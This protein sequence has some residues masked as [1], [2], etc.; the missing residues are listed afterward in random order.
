M[1]RIFVT[2]SHQFRS[3]KEVVPK[4][5]DCESDEGEC[6]SV[7]DGNRDFMKELEKKSRRPFSGC[8]E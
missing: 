8:G 5:E 2:V 1:G 6:M 4:G 7:R 3:S